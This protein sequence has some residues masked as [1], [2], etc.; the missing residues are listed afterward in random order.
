MRVNSFTSVEI[1]AL[2]MNKKSTLLHTSALPYAL[3]FICLPAFSYMNW[4]PT[5]I[6][7]PP[8]TQ[9]PT[10]LTAIPRPLSDIP[11]SDRQF[12]NHVFSMVLKAVQSKLIILNAL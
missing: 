3:Y 11:A 5:N 7:P 1:R 9:Y 10:H 12:I 8:G 4:Y 6:S 2:K